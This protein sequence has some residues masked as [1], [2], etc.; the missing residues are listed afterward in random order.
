LERDPSWPDSIRRWVNV[1]SP[2]DQVCAGTQ[3][4]PIYDARIEDVVVDN[5]HRGHDPEPYLCARVTGVA[6][7][8]ALGC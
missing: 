6:I 2:T 5:G 4:A 1:T 7:R 8:D 3:L